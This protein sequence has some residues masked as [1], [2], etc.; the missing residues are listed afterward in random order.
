MARAGELVRRGWVVLDVA[1]HLAC[2][3]RRAEP[4]D[5]V[6]R[7]IDPGRDAGRRDHVA[8]ID[9]A[10]VRTGVI[11]RPSGSSSSNAL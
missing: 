5:E 6:E 1:P 9:E 3:V 8:D 2:L 10:L 4:S 11:S 7:H